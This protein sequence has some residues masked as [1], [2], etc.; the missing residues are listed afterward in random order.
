[1]PGALLAA[2]PVGYRTPPESPDFTSL[3]EFPFG[4]DTIQLS[5][6]AMADY[7]TAARDLGIRYIGSCC[8]S[9]SGHVRAMARALGKLPSAERS[10]RS[11]TGKAMSA[12]EYYGHTEVEA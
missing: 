1:V 9:V 7:A 11:T 5:R 12:Y 6:G 3:P 4:L 8:G 10:W 2:Q